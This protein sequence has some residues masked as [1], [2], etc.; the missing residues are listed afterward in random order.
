MPFLIGRK[1][2]EK[3]KSGLSTGLHT[4]VM[5]AAIFAIDEHLKLWDHAG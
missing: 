2:N 3:T 5:G 1:T 4:E